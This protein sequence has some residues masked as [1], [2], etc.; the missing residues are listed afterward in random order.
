MKKIY[1]EENKEVIDFSLV[2]ENRPIFAYEDNIL[3]GMIVNEESKGWIT[4]LGG[5]LG[6]N[7]HHYDLKT[8]IQKGQKSGYSYWIN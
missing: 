4:R 8:C 3:C 7:G 5:T 1:L 6:A 2:N